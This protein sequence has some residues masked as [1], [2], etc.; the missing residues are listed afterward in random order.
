MH[1]FLKDEDDWLFKSICTQ[2]TGIDVNKNQSL[3]NNSEN[4]SVGNVSKQHCHVLNDGN[5]E[6]F[7]N[8]PLDEILFRQTES[9]SHL[10]ST[11]PQIKANA[12]KLS[13]YVQDRITYVRKNNP[14][15]QTYLED[16]FFNFEAWPF[17]MAELFVGKNIADF[18]YSVR[19]KICLFFWGNGGTYEIMYALNMFFGPRAS[20]KKPEEQYQFENSCRKARDLFKTYSE[21]CHNP[22]SVWFILIIKL[23]ITVGAKNITQLIPTRDG[24]STYI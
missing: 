6:I 19:N 2:A 15:A 21:Q 1:R 17:Y 16:M 3:L 24:F 4:Q 11:K 20:L 14:I 12:K 22:K 10:S 8:F 13:N 18:S 23:D 5:D 7:K 9:S